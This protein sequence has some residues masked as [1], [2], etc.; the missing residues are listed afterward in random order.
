MG[1]GGAT[2]TVCGVTALPTNAPTPIPIVPRPQPNH[3]LHW[4]VR[5]EKARRLL[6]LCLKGNPKH[7]LHL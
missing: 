7:P 4:P 1:G 2:Y 6:L 5:R 3:C